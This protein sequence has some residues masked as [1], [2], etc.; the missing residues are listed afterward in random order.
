VVFFLFEALQLYGYLEF[1]TDNR[2]IKYVFLEKTFPAMDEFTIAFWIHLLL[3]GA[4]AKIP[5]SIF[6]YSL[7]KAEILIKKNEKSKKKHDYDY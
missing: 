3:N 7:G 2:N 6:S 1:G 4:T 5:R